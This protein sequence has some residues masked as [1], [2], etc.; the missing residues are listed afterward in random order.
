MI[1]DKKIANNKI[2][3]NYTTQQRPAK[4]IEYVIVNQKIL[5]KNKQTDNKSVVTLKNKKSNKIK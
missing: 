4:I 1:E 2:K 3:V 5:E